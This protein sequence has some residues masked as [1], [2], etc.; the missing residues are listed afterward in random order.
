M[1]KI[2]VFAGKVK[3]LRTTLHTKL[4]LEMRMRIHAAEKGASKNRYINSTRV[5]DGTA[6]TGRGINGN[7]GHSLDR[8][9]RTFCFRCGRTFTEGESYDR[10]FVHGQMVPVCHDDRSCIPIIPSRMKRINE[11]A[12]RFHLAVEDDVHG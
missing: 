5:L 2:F 7:H 10:I 11:I 1:E 6:D 9:D 3:D 4:Q 12:T 8:T